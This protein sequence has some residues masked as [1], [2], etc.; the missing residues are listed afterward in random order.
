VS[1]AFG[2]AVNGPVA[3]A[4]GSVVSGVSVDICG[5]YS[6]AEGVSKEGR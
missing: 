4:V 2:A 5:V 1:F 3:V 6:V